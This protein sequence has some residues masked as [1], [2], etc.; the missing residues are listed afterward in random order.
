[1]ICIDGMDLPLETPATQAELADRVRVLS[2]AGTPI[3]PVGGATGLDYGGLPDRLGMAISLA[4]LDRVIDY[5]AR[6]LTITVE[7]GMTFAR[8]HAILAAEG[9]WLPVD[10][11][12]PVRATVGG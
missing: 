10:V 3:Y 2:A 12:D 6:D 7:A 1:M 5:P 4:M 8:L 11:P 9:Q